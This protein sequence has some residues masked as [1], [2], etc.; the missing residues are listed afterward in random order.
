MRYRVFSCALSMANVGSFS[1]SFQ[2]R[3]IS[4]TPSKRD[5]KLSCVL[6]QWFQMRMLVLTREIALHQDHQISEMSVI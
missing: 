5:F 3:A 2:D 1:D 4:P 6:S